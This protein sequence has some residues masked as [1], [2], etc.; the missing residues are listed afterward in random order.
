MAKIYGLNGVLSGRQGSTVFAVRNGMNIARKY[1]PVVSNPKSMAQ[2]ASRAKLKALSQLSAL[3]GRAIVIPRQGDVSPRNMFTKVNYP[4]TSF[5]N[6]AATIDMS[7]VK[8][9]AGLSAMPS[10]A[11]SAHGTESATIG[12]SV[13]PTVAFDRVIYVVMDV[14]PDGTIDGSRVITQAAPGV[15]NLFTT[16]IPLVD[17]NAAH[18]YAYGIRILDTN[19]R[20]RYESIEDNG[21]DAIL[22]II[23][24]ASANDLSVSQSVYM[25][26]PPKTNASAKVD[27]EVGTR[28]RKK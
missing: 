20:V 15:D 6:D 23:R 21:T 2:V 14:R 5:A 22:D 26:I 3:L 24:S 1:Q 8:I 27:E 17:I 11:V 19:Y 7:A 4:A 16:V 18:V 12:L 10:I 9:T 25:R 28:S 13:A